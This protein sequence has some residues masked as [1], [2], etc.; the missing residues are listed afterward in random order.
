MSKPPR[1]SGTTAPAHWDALYREGDT[2]WDLGEAAPPLVDLLAGPDAP[3]PGRLIALGSGR[4]HDAL[5]F[6]AHGFDVLGVDFAPSA[7][8]TA[9]EAAA[10]QGLTD[11][12]RFLQADIFALPPEY[13][14]AFDVVLEH[15]CMC[16]LDPRLLDEYA[17]LVTRLLRPGGTYVALFYTHGR[18]GG[19]PYTTNAA[20]IR[21]LF[22]PRLEIVHLAPAQRSAPRFAGKEWLSLM[23]KAAS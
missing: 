18:P 16:A 20:E 12:V 1:Y 21:R 23:R 10:A 17:A 9:T 22:T 2:G 6:A 8:V 4:G 3:P 13:R 14:A 19:P 7:V 15:T 5:L 11:R